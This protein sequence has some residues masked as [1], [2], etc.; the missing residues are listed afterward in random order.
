MNQLESRKLRWKL[1]LGLELLTSVLAVPLAVLFII[2]AGGYDFN[3]SI[4]LIVASMIS[5]TCSYIVP[6]I[7]F[8]YLGR[9]LSKL[10]DSI[11]FS[12]NSKEKSEVKTR[13][14]NFPLSNTFFYLVQWSLGVPYAWWLL[15]IF[16]VPT[17]LESF[18]FLF[19]PFIIY[20]ILG[21]SHFFL[22]ESSFVDLLESERLNE[23]QADSEKMR[24]VGVHARILSTIVA[25]ATLPIVVLGYLLFEE[26]SGWVKLGDVT[27]PLILT[28]VFML[29]AVVIVSYQLSSTI[30][31]NSENMI[32][33]FGE[34]SDGNL[35]HILPMVSSDELGSNSKALNEFVKRLRI[36]VK[37]V[38]REA[39]KLSGSSKSLG[40]NT[41]ELSRKMQDQAASTEEMSSGVE[42]IAASIHSTASRAESQ[43]QIAKK[44]Q[45]SLAELEARIRQVHV[46]LLETKGDADRM[47]SE[48]RSGEEALQGTQKAME[49]IEESTAKMGATVNV[50]RE[51][52]DRIG[53]LSLNAAIEA[54]RAGE[55]GKGF[56]VV[57]QEIAKLGE[58]TQENAKRITGAISEALNATKSGREVIESTQTVFQRIG[59]TVAVTLDRVSEV[60]SLSDSQLTASEQVKSAFTDLSLSSEEIRNHTQ[61]QAQTSTEFSKTIVT[62]SETTEFLNQVVTQI[63][64]LAVK[65]NEQAGKL[66]SEVEFFKT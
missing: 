52:T 17:F 22:T 2:T 34:M 25:I 54:A 59:D 20:P 49:A 64:E 30:R 6:S 56:A 50:I 13:I 5:L 48:T 14:L 38:V 31:R 53:L 35:T 47:K 8:L 51:I 36:I 45:S 16:F 57:A 9:I 33:I 60:A 3:K 65:L 29:I 58:Q 21:V 15:R 55:A 4:A 43:A 39:E 18:P 10:N 1:T 7:R 27:I 19:L 41:R 32:Q 24:K 28:L 44:A 11:W 23:V 63:D 12:L 62:I 26:T 46:A 66:R 61:E 42:E 40:E 37:S